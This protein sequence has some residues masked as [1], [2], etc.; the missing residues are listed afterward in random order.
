MCFEHIWSDLPIFRIRQDQIIFMPR[1]ISKFESRCT[2]F[3]QTPQL[4]CDLF[5]FC[6]NGKNVLQVSS[7]SALLGI[8]GA[9]FGTFTRLSFF[10][11]FCVMPVECLSELFSFLASVLISSPSYILLSCASWFY[12]IEMAIET[13][14][15]SEGLSSQRSSL[16][17][18]HVSCFPKRTLSPN[19]NFCKS[20]SFAVLPFSH[21]CSS[22]CVVVLAGLC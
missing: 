22:M 14:Q 15:K 17:N 21:L 5:I 3:L 19:L 7:I 11:Y 8:S 18:S 12:Q 20:P 4:S 9:C 6:Y 2:F 10:I 1:L 13:L 16:L